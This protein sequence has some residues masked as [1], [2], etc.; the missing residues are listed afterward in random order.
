MGIWRART[1]SGLTTSAAMAVALTERGFPSRSPSFSHLSEAHLV[2]WALVK[3][4]LGVG[5]IE[6]EVGDADPEIARVAP[7]FYVPL[8]CGC[9]RTRAFKTS[10]RYACLR[11]YWQRR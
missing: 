6:C 1:S 11:P 7:A 3:A 2:Q 4:G 10:R 5:V 8:R 9:P